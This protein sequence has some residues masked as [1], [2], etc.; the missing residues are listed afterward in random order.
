V[1]SYPCLEGGL[2]LRV[3]EQQCI[4]LGGMSLVCNELANVYLKDKY[5]LCFS[6]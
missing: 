4:W 5:S 1:D 6:V 3:N 2:L